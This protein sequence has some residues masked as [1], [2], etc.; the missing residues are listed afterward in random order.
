MKK[1]MIV[2]VATLIA[3]FLVVVALIEVP[4]Q[5]SFAEKIETTAD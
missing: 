1:S 2:T 4:K 5:Y 3:I